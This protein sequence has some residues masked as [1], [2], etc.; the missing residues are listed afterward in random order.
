MGISIGDHIGT[1]IE[2]HSPIP[3]EAPGRRDSFNCGMPLHHHRELWMKEASALA[4]LYTPRL[5]DNLRFLGPRFRG[6]SQD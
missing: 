3:Y 5:L 6:K 1:T 2:I 4:C